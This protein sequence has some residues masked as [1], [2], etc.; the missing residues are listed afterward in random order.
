MYVKGELIGGLDIVKEMI[1]SGEL[2]DVMPTAEDL[3]TRYFC[4]F[5][6]YKSNLQILIR[7]S[8]FDFTFFSYYLNLN[9]LILVIIYFAICSSYITVSLMDSIFF[10]WYT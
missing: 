5:V 8:L 2:K 4:L 9:I 10:I 6:Y 1:E 3:N 7:T